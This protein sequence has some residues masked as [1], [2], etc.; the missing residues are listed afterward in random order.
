MS[1]GQSIQASYFWRGI[2]YLLFSGDHLQKTRA[3]PA[4]K[5]TA[6]LESRLLAHAHL[7]R[8]MVRQAVNL[9]IDLPEERDVT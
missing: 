6:N 2:A 1:N 3:W 8:E 4:E 7:S 5:I 9:I